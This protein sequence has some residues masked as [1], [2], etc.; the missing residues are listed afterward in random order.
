MEEGREGRERA[1]I[2]QGPFTFNVTRP[3]GEKR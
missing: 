2:A 3:L 1:G